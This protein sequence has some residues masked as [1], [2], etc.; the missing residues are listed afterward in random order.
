M[1]EVGIAASPLAGLRVLDLSHVLAG[2]YAAYHLALLGAEVIKIEKPPAGDAIRDLEI[3]PDEGG[4]TAAFQGVNASKRAIG[5]DLA[6]PEGRAVLERLIPT[7]AVFLENF[8]PGKIA[9]LGFGPD[10]VA[11]LNPAIVYASISAW[12][13]TGDL[14]GRPGY[15]HVMQAATGMMWLQGA[16]PAA[17]PVKVGF[18]AIDMAAGMMGAMAIMAGLM[19]RRTGDTG[20]IVLDVS[21]A[22]AALALMSA[23]ANRYLMDGAA[24]ARIGNGAFAASPGSNVFRTTDGWLAI[25]ANTLGQFDALVGVLGRPELATTP[26]WLRLRPM[27]ADTIL[28]DCGTPQLEVALKGAFLGRE[29]E[30][31]ETLLSAAGVPAAAVRS[32]A[33][34][35]DGPYRRT[36]GFSGE[37]P[38]GLPGQRREVLGASFRINGAAPLPRAAAPRFGAD[39][40]PL[41]AELGY[42]QAEIAALRDAGAVR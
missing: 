38:H 28:R 29:S 19:R 13:Q 26:D 14:A 2:P 42:G 20:P 11:V 22:D 18:P 15:D 30:E 23:P 5:L 33:A 17:P 6:K 32:P 39:T 16:N 37:V 31:W 3:R 40:D 21:M 12:G 8:R 9:R 10:Q 1:P 27:A 4:V 7:A 34:F 36:A 35:L 25:A 41:L 24:P